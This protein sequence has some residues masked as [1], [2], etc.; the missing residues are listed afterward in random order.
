MCSR[1]I[2]TVWTACNRQ[3][4]VINDDSTGRDKEISEIVRELAN[5]PG[6]RFVNI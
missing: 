6:R 2:E 3:G 4:S 1:W 5:S